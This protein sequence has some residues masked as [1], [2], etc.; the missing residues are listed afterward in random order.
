MWVKPLGKGPLQINPK[1]SEDGTG[2]MGCEGNTGGAASQCV[3]PRGV[4]QF[5][6]LY[7]E[8]GDPS[9]PLVDPN[10]TCPAKIFQ[11]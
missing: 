8:G 4:R 3:T 7:G 2:Q 10:L 6:G 1:S 5:G 11:D 9:P